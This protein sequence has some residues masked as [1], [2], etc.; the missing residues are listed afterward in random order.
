VDS[1]LFARTVGPQANG[2]GFAQNGRVTLKWVDFEL[3][4]DEDWPPQ[5]SLD[6]TIVSAILLGL[7]YQQR[8]SRVVEGTGPA[9]PQQ[10]GAT[11]K[12]LIP[13]Q[14][15]EIRSSIDRPPVVEDST[16]KLK[17]N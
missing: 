7:P 13:A 12:V 9:T 1:T 14:W 15:G 2:S 16:P 4:W 17:S 6:L 11:A 5:S 3:A 10:P 8:L